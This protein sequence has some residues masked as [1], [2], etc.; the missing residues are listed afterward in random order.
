MLF[1]QKKYSNILKKYFFQNIP[2]INTLTF[3]NYLNS[4]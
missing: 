2:K 3:K 4:F 1:V